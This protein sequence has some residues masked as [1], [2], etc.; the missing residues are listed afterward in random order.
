M[1]LIV[2]IVQS[3]LLE[4]SRTQQENENRYI[5]SVLVTYNRH[6]RA[7]ASLLPFSEIGQCDEIDDH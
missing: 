6:E 5:F 2:Q 3:S 7:S 4:K 1:M